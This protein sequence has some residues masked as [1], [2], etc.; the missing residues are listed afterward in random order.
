MPNPSP[1]TEHLKKHQIKKGEVRNPI[2]AG[3]HDPAL[4]AV[5]FMTKDEMAEVGKLILDKDFQQLRE[6]ADSLK[7]NDGKKKNISVLKAMVASVAMRI[8]SKGDMHALDILL[9]R[10][11]GKVKD[12]VQL[13]GENGKPFEMIIRDYREKKNEPE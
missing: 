11:V 8:I 3:A 12:E 7:V 1:K 2:G 10:L 6:M 5:R 9:N 13:N 4:R